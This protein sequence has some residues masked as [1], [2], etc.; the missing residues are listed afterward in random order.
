MPA[1]DA[2]ELAE[3]AEAYG[4]GEIRLIRF[5]HPDTNRVTRRSGIPDQHD[6]SGAIREQS[7]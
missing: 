3:L 2:I 1:E 4:S 7:R 6:F 5:I